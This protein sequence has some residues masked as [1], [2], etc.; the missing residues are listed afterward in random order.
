KHLSYRTEE[1]YLAWIRRF[2]LFHD[3]RHP[4]DMGADEVRA[5]LT[6]RAV[7]QN[8]AASTQNQAFAALLFLYRD[9]LQKPLGNIE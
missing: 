9:F 7:E 3:K 4:A 5:F 1:A 6:H 8:V 2:I